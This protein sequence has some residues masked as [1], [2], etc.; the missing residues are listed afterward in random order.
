M[1]ILRDPGK[2]FI[3]E[4]CV[5]S[6]CDCVINEFFENKV[7]TASIYRRILV[8]SSLL[9]T[10]RVNSPANISSDERQ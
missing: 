4:N 2:D 8:G 3:P 5:S 10:C 1:N 9:V 7:A 6:F